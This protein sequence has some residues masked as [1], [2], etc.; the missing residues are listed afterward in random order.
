VI[1]VHSQLSRVLPTFLS[2]IFL[3]VDGCLV[4]ACVYYMH[5]RVLCSGVRCSVFNLSIDVMHFHSFVRSFDRSVRMRV[6]WYNRHGIIVIRLAFYTI[7]SRAVIVIVKPI[8][9]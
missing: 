9:P 6:L 1:R 7:S 3:T 2:V 4:D 5:G 8:F